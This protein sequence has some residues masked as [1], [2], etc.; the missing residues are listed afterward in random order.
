MMWKNKNPFHEGNG[1]FVFGDDKDIDQISPVEEMEGR[2]Q[3]KNFS[4]AVVGNDKKYSF[5]PD[6][7]L[8]CIPNGFD[9]DTPESS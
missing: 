8:R 3:V 9:P 1:V 7:I 2:Q 5:L 6:R 4:S